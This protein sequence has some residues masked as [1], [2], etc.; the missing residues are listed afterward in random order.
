MFFRKFLLGLA[1][2]LGLAVLASCGGG[3]GSPG[4]SSGT[5]IFS[6]APATGLTVKVGSS[7]SYNVRGGSGNYQAITSNDQVATANVDG[8]TLFIYGNAAGTATISVVD[9]A[10]K[11]YTVA[12]TVGN[13][14]PF[15]T[16]APATL[17]IAPGTSLSYVVGGGVPLYTASSSNTNFVTVSLSGNT[18]TVFGKPLT[19]QA[20]STANITLM[21]A[22]NTTVTVAV[23]V[24]SVP[25]GLTPNTGTSIID[26]VLVATIIGGT[27]PYTASV[28]NKEVASAT[29]IDQNTLQ[30]I[31]RQVGQTI[32]TVLDANLQTI[33]FNLTV[34][35]G[36]PEFRLSPSA[37][38]VSEGEGGS[39]TLFAYGAKKGVLKAFSSDLS[40]I[41]TNDGEVLTDGGSGSIVIDMK[42]TCVAANTDVTITVIDSKGNRGR[43][44]ITI[45]NNLTSA[46]ACTQT[47][48]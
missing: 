5:A 35:A 42:N 4:L 32:V 19:G 47:N 17:N 8:D 25:L 1:F 15:Y 30:M 13:L 23:T 40:R 29:V 9:T 34:G 37:L 2:V 7:Q 43:S 24:S 10:N 45:V 39:I 20:S 38:S 11:I 27:P 16:T 46:A 44:T 22:S 6:T 41:G 36:T 33:A 3:G 14:I 18:L 31:G 21:D 26:D 12:L 48:T 28:G